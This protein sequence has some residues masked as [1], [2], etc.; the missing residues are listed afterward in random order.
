MRYDLRLAHTLQAL[1][2]MDISPPFGY[3][4][5]VPL[6]K[7][8]RLHLPDAAA[9]PQFARELNAIPVSFTEFG[10]AGRDYPLVFVSGDADQTFAAVAVLG[11][12]AGENLF[13]DEDGWGTGVY[14]PAYVRRYPF[15]MTRV[16]LDEVIQDE[17]MICVERA[18]VAAEGE[19]GESMFDTAGTATPRWTEIQKLLNEYEAD[20][21]RTR[22]MCAIFAD[23]GL[24]EPFTVQAAP[25]GGAPMNLTGMH[26]VNES[27]IEFLTADQLR[28]LARKGLFARLYTHLQ[29][30]DN[31][32]RLLDRRAG[33][34]VATN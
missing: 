15:C 21:E 17:R 26:R 19:S 16:T 2:R 7:T 8:H 27:R 25:N 20:L 6:Q 31:F 14:V 3:R 11:F 12:A 4:D 22:E 32:G 29:S 28:T 9:L 10:V 34:A 13:V 1:P 33:R 24:L 5:I 30:L 23:F 18:N